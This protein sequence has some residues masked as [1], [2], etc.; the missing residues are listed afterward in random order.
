MLY[1][2]EDNKALI[3]NDTQRQESN[4]ETRVKNPQSFS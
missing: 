2:F 3:L 1:V 4:N